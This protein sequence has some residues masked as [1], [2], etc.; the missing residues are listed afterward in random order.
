MLDRIY[1]WPLDRRSAFT[2][3]RIC[4]YAFLYSGK[5]TLPLRRVSALALLASS[6]TCRLLSF[7]SWYRRSVFRQRRGRGSRSLL[8]L[9]LP[10]LEM[11]TSPQGG[12]GLQGACGGSVGVHELDRRSPALSSLERLCGACRCGAEWYGVVDGVGSVAAGRWRCIFTRA[13]G[14]ITKQMFTLEASPQISKTCFVES[15]LLSFH[16]LESHYQVLC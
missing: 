16:S 8:L 4:V 11:L 7:L 15:Y 5:Q 12:L 2:T 3:R 6:S 10:S 13:R 9:L 1:C 14:S